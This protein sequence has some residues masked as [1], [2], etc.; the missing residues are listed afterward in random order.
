MGNR[1]PPAFACK[2][3]SLPAASV[4]TA[5]LIPPRAFTQNLRRQQSPPPTPTFVMAGS[6]YR[7]TRPPRDSREPDDK[8]PT[9][10]CKCRVLV[11][12]KGAK[13]GWPVRAA[14]RRGHDA[15]SFD[16]N[17]GF[18]A[19][20][21][22]PRRHQATASSPKPWCLRGPISEGAGTSGRSQDQSGGLDAAPDC[23]SY[24]P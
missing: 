13:S 23:S 12:P 17:C 4:A 20:W 3:R 8:R 16:G 1:K 21:F 14:A 10:A 18:I 9:P 11:T 22:S 7:A 2:T 15:F 19:F 5:P 6:R 24:V